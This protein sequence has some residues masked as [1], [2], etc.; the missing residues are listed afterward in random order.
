M[1]EILN[2]TTSKPST[3][4]YRING[5]KA[6][7]TKRYKIIYGPM[8][9]RVASSSRERARGMSLLYRHLIMQL[10]NLTSVIKA[11]EASERG[12]GRR[13]ESVTFFDLS[14]SSE[15]RKV[16]ELRIRNRPN[17]FRS[18]RNSHLRLKKS[19]L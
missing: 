16:R 7:V 5:C 17:N 14:R 10:T 4:I 8:P 2:F 13:P 11:V 1:L 15:L 6:R 9:L 18:S 12:K 19:H 3:K